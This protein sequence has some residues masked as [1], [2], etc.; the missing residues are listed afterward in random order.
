VVIPPI[1]MVETSVD[2]NLPARTV[3]NEEGRTK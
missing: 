2:L 1:L 3:S